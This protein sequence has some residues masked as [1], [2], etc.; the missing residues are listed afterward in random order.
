[1]IQLLRMV[2]F[3][4]ATFKN[5]WVLFLFAKLLKYSTAMKIPLCC[6]IISHV[7]PLSGEFLKRGYPQI[8]H[9]NWIHPFWGARNFE[10]TSMSLY[11][12][13]YVG[14]FRREAPKSCF[15]HVFFGKSMFFWGTPIS[16]HLVRDKQESCVYLVINSISNWCVWHYLSNPI[17]QLDIQKLIS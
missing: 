12:K 4:F 10:E 15:F 17:K 14:F 13:S 3:H 16:I 6:P 1:M 7:I 8:I 2:M 9:V 11:P 5:Q